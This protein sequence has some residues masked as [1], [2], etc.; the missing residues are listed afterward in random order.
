MNKILD[1]KGK[2]DAAG[3]KAELERLALLSDE[4]VYA[5]LKKKTNPELSTLGDASSALCNRVAEF[6][7]RKDLAAKK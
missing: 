6:A 3:V 2:A 1:E 7:H 5:E 4:E